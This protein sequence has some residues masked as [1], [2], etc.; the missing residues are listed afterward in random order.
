MAGFAHGLG[1][2]FSDVDRDG[3][4]D[5]YVANDTKPNRLY[6]NVAWPG[7]ADADPAGL[8]FRFEERAAAAGVADPNAG[9]G[10][11]GGDF[12]G[13]G[14]TDLFVTNLAGRGTASS[15]APPDENDPSFADV[16]P[17]GARARWL[18]GWGVS[19][20]DLDLDT[21]LDL[22][23]VNG[24]IPVTDLAEDEQLIQVFGDLTAQG[25]AGRFAEWAARSAWPGS[26][27]SS[28]AGAPWRTTTTTETSTSPS[29]RW[30]GTWPCSRTSTRA[31]AGS[32]SSST[33][34][35]R[36]QR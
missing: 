14:R 3:D 2:V 8:G 15:A 21:D 20:A 30:V 4:L 5:I 22:V 13:D 34:S 27:R 25:M 36:V 35:L 29:A 26:D 11:A 6:E 9:M 28:R 12:D 33:G 17:P 23:V 32:R 7:G 31:A 24:D 16:R 18:T 19:W 10:V 1:V